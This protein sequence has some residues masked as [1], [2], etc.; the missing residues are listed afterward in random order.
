MSESTSLNVLV[1]DDDD[2]DRQAI[3][4]ALSKTQ[5]PAITTEAIDK[6][7]AE[8]ALEEQNFDCIFMD[9]F[10]PGENGLEMVKHLR[11]KGVDTPI[12]I[13]TGQGDEALVADILRAGAS[14]YL[15]KNQLSSDTLQRA[16]NY[17]I[18][19]RE[20]ELEREQA[21]SSAIESARIKSEFL[22]NMSHEIRTPMNGVL[23]ML[24]LLKETSLDDEQ[25]LY[26]DNAVAS[27]EALLT[28]ISD[29]LDFSKIEAGKLNLECIEFDIRTLVEETL[30]SLAEPALQK[31]LDLSCN[32]PPDIPVVALGD[33]MRLR[34]VLN[35][36]VHNANK[37]TEHGEIS[38]TVSVDEVTDT[39]TT[40]RF[41][42][43][44]TGIGI[45]EDA[46][47]QIFDSFS[48]GDGSTTRRFGGTGLGLAI[49]RQLVEHME[50][51]IGVSSRTE[52][53]SMFWFTAR[54]GN[55][56]EARPRETVL[57]ECDLTHIVLLEPHAGVSN[58]IEHYLHHYGINTTT[59]RSETELAQCLE[60]KNADAVLISSRLCKPALA[61]MQSIARTPVT[62]LVSNLGDRR[63]LKL[64]GIHCH[65]SKPVRLSALEQTLK[66]I[67]DIKTNMETKQIE[68]SAE[69]SNTDPDKY[70]VLL[71][72]DNPINAKVG[73]AILRKLNC[74][75]VC[76]ADGLEALEI[77]KDQ[78]FDLILM[79]CQM[80]N[81]DGFATTAHI[82]E[83]EQQGTRYHRSEARIPIVALTANVMQGY[84]EKCFEAG[85]DDYL[86][87]PFKVD[88]LN[89]T[90]M[91]HLE[92]EQDD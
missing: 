81:L 42:V 67:C 46:Q 70:Q 12:V 38:V 71:V 39:H 33:P 15:S 57:P 51:R 87:K 45:S 31:N 48:Q 21:H 72:E 75:T 26:V 37:F 40:Y 69:L 61:V 44:D 14:D 6:A 18:A 30:E 65:L 50:G 10:L 11:D 22:A 80:P 35:N 49:C 78:R 55:L 3:K 32:I 56:P 20:A 88:A 25:K 76:A 34:Q 47:N 24:S 7:S 5:Y 1:I 13:L 79:D 8:Q 68:K 4:R 17:V 54:L 86:S 66:S 62:V 58:S 82:R 59:L 63:N 36:L 60:Q 74:N 16:L 89:E 84:A 77:L 90:I 2:V 41:E 91:R 9:Y 19:V 73:A 23:G 29:I 83:A 27:G 43:S 85:M 52:E 64:E 92:G 28:L 53:G